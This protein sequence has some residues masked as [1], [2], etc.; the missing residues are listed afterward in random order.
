MSSYSS[1]QRSLGQ[2]PT[3]IDP[4]DIANKAYVDAQVATAGTSDLEFLRDKELSGDIQKQQGTRNS[5]GVI[6]SF[7]PAIGV[8]YFFLSAS[9]GAQSPTAR[10][11]SLQVRN[12]AVIR[13]HMVLKI[14]GAGATGD[15]NTNADNS[16]QRI[17]R[18]IGDG[19]L[20]YD[21]NI[22][23]ISGATECNACMEGWTQTT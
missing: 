19:A 18:L 16:H 22:N 3:P 9:V 17:D 11:Y 7:T 4:N 12:N 13:D 20:I 8:T 1:K 6:V 15:Q 10:F 23:L 14:A 21:L 5:T 2:T